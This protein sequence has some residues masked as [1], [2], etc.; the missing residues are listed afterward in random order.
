[1]L[2]SL[3]NPATGPNTVSVS[4]TNTTPSAFDAVEC[5]SISFSNVDQ[6]TPFRNLGSATG[7]GTAPSKAIAS[8]VGNMVLDVVVAGADVTSSGQTN[9]W[10]KNVSTNSAGGNGAQST[11]A[12]AASVT[13][14]YTVTSDWWA[15]VGIDVV[16]AASGA[17][18]VT[19]TLAS[20]ATEAI[21]NA[22]GGTLILTLTGDTWVAAGATFNAERQNLING[23][24]SAQSETHGWDAEVKAKL[25]VGDV[26][27]TSDTVVTIT[28]SAQSGYA[29]TATETVTATIPATAVVLNAQIVATPTFTVT[30]IA[31]ARIMWL[32][33]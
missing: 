26:V 29:I 2:Y 20:G 1:V 28:A 21:V 23:I 8:A 11:A 5:G 27:R 30:P 18:V 16:A 4:F 14:S 33:A 12:G 6:T 24:D 17:G 22:V 15:I 7:S 31:N 19:G 13:M 32:A 3:V 9:R 10:L 25:A